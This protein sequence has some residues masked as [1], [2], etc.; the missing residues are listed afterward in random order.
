MIVLV[1]PLP[2]FHCRSAWKSGNSPA[3]AG[4]CL[5][6]LVSRVCLPSLVSSYSALSPGLNTP[7]STADGIVLTFLREGK[8]VTCYESGRRHT[9]FTERIPVFLPGTFRT[10]DGEKSL[11]ISSMLVELWAV[12]VSIYIYSECGLAGLL[13]SLRQFKLFTTGCPYT[14]QWV[15]IIIISVFGGHGG[16]AVSSH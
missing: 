5:S 8:Y 3:I 7:L 14:L 16:D 12:L 11:H 4:V 10:S 15:G 2:F 6:S 1:I 9:T 13:L